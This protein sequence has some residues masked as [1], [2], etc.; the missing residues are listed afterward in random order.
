M[1]IN[2]AYFDNI[3]KHAKYTWPTIWYMVY[4]HVALKWKNCDLRI[5]VKLKLYPFIFMSF[6]YAGLLIFSILVII[7]GVLTIFE[8]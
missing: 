8:C 1:T 7:C 6:E 3:F 2:E 4:G 5:D